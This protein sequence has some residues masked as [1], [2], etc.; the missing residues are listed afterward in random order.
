MQGYS[1]QHSKPA[2]ATPNVRYPHPRVCIS[3]LS[4]CRTISKPSFWSLPAAPSAILALQVLLQWLIRL[5]GKKQVTNPPASARRTSVKLSRARGADQRCEPR[6]CCCLIACC[7]CC[8]NVAFSDLTSALTGRV[9]LSP[10]KASQELVA[11]GFRPQ[12]CCRCAA[13]LIADA[14]RATAAACTLLQ[15]PN[16]NLCCRNS[17]KLSSSVSSV[18][19][20][21]STHCCPWCALPSPAASSVAVAASREC[22][23]RCCHCKS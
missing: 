2:P 23:C 5:G 18:A 19:L 1:A 9:L 16:T 8:C 7:A 21:P 17:P 22:C 10:H 14:A 4:H 6:A 11:L 20:Q 12:A 13:L 3:L 15:L